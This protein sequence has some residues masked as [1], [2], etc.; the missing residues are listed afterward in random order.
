MLRG[1]DEA[2]KPTNTCSYRRIFMHKTYWFYKV[3]HI[4]LF[5]SQFFDSAILHDIYGVSANK[6]LKIVSIYLTMLHLSF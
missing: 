6:Y 1:M 2:I 4:F 3:Y 5:Q